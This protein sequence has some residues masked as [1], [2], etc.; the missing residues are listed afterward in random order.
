MGPE[1]I[2]IWFRLGPLLMVV[3]ATEESAGMAFLLVWELAFLRRF[4]P[5]AFDTRYVWYIA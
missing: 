5:F 2:N 1:H 4:D 3:T